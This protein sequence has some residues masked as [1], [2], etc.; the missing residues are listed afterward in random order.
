LDDQIPISDSLDHRAEQ[1]W[2]IAHACQS[3]LGRTAFAR[4]PDR[5]PHSVRPPTK[6]GCEIHACRPDKLTED[7]EHDDRI[8]SSPIAAI[9]L[10]APQFRHNKLHTNRFAGAGAMAAES[11]VHPKTGHL[12]R[13]VLVK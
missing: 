5:I 1:Q 9:P 11:V 3:A 7:V 13:P 4:T 10:D 8:Q 2:A 6:M 12:N